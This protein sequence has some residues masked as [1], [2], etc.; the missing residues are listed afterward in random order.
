M[1]A[2]VG[3]SELSWADHAAEDNRVTRLPRLAQI[4]RV[5]PDLFKVAI[6]QVGVMDMLRF[7]K[8]TIGFNWISDYGDRKSVV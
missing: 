4:R 8:F 3:Q 7:Q 1:L 2:D 6:P 5:R